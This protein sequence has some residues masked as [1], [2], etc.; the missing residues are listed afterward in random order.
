[1]FDEHAFRFGDAEEEFVKIFF[2]VA[3]QRAQRYLRAVLER[4]DLGILLE[5]QFNAE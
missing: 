1:M 2:V 4:D 3:A 5:F